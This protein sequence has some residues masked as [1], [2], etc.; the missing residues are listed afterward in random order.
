M[1][2]IA[3]ITDLHVTT[4]KDPLNQRR[5]EERLRQVMK[6][7]QKVVQGKFFIFATQ[8]LDYPKVGLPDQILRMDF[9]L[10]CHLQPL[11]QPLINV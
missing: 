6:A 2:T 8:L 3:Q 9:L 4:E 11:M 10:N 5:N 7:I 1:L